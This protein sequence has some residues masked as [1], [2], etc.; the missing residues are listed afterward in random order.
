MTDV[1]AFSNDH[2]CLSTRQRRYVIMRNITLAKH[3]QAHTQKHI[4]THTHT[5]TH[6]HISHTLTLSFIAL[7]FFARSM[8]LPRLSLRGSSIVCKSMG[9]TCTASLTPDSLSLAEK[10]FQSNVQKTSSL[11]PQSS[12][13]TICDRPSALLYNC[14]SLIKNIPN[15]AAQ[16]SQTYNSPSA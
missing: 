14:L 4:L 3:I 2:R 13:N 15:L 10:L 7:A 1:H 8:I 12:L 9:T 6:T 11:A 16:L 5:Y